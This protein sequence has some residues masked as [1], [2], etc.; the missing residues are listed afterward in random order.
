VAEPLQKAGYVPSAWGQ[1]FHSLTH[2]EALGAGAAGPGKT[3]VLLNDPLAQIHVEHQR[4]VDR[5]HPF[6]HSRMGDS[7][8][9]A[10][11][12]R[13]TTKMLEQ[14]V[15]R[16]LRVYPRIDPGMSWMESKLTATFSSGF[17]YQFGHCKDPHDYE[18]F[19][20]YEFTYCAFDELT[21]FEEEQYDQIS[22][23]VRSTDPVLSEMLKVRSMSNPLMRRGEIGDNF[24]ISNPNW[25]RDR[26]VRPAPE[27]R[28]T[29]KRKIVHP[30]GEVE[31]RTCI[32][33]P[34]TIDDNPNK[35]FVKQ[36]RARLLAAKPHIRQALLYGDWFVTPDSF[37]A[38][39]WNPTIHVCK[40]FTIPSDWRVFRS[41]DWGYKKPG[42][43][44]WFAMDP[45]DTLYVIRQ[46]M[47]I[48]KTDAEI[49]KAIYLVE[50]DM[51]YWKDNKS[52][53][54]GPADTQLWEER[55]DSG[56]T[57]AAT[58][59]EL[60]VQWTKAD[61]KSRQT[62]AER[63]TAR[64]KDHAGGTATPGLVIFATCRNL[65]ETL[66]AMQT[67]PTF[68][69][70]PLD[71]GDDHAHDA[72]CYAVAYASYGPAGVAKVKKARPEWYEEDDN[73][74]A[75]QPSRGRSGY[76]T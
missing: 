59:A 29:L 39:E 31:Y 15:Q 8:G 17:R 55:G 72:L 21:Q 32:Y 70:V 2:H 48:G 38:D 27:G 53:L 62:N 68:T 49:A 75:A 7:T 46:M 42:C 44:L 36:Y 11:H 19:M 54:T 3:E 4:C 33:L 23:R 60:G 45:D 56:K 76:G 69:E 9:W 16:F 18:N 63:I 74:D 10:I 20:S 61:K 5:S 43:V 65:I 64:L 47:F 14:S 30:D 1:V 66:P 52:S 71:G 67:D 28:V 25:V 40:P 50:D 22:T 24:S 41:M 57:K 73:D 37:Y 12:L 58:M 34:A 6:R 51:G 13:R 35:E 26:F